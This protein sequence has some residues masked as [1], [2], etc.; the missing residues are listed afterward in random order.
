MN[1]QPPTRCPCND[2]NLTVPVGTT[3]KCPGCG[4]VIVG[5]TPPLKEYLPGSKTYYLGSV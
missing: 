3:Y 5:A 2:E 4:R 1:Q